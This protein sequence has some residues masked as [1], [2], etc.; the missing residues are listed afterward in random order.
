MLDA[1]GMQPPPI[2]QSQSDG[3]GMLMFGAWSS[4]ICGFLGA[5][6]IWFVLGRMP[7]EY[8][9]GAVN[10][11]MIGLGAGVLLQGVVLFAIL[12]GMATIIRRLER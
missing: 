5:A 12:D 2:A 4:L 9:P 1:P 6:T 3:T 7:D 11:P 10:W 8:G